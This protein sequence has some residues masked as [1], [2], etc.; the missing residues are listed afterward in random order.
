MGDRRRWRWARVWKEKPSRASPEGIRAPRPARGPRC[1]RRFCSHLVADP[2]SARALGSQDKASRGPQLGA[3][4]LRAP[5]CGATRWHRQGRGWEL[6]RARPSARGLHGQ[7]SPLSLC[8]AGLSPLSRR[9]RREKLMFNIY[10]SF[11]PGH[12]ISVWVN[13]SL[14]QTLLSF[15]SLDHAG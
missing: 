9:A 7:G 12:N 2:S 13:P 10:P 5:R 6:P 4:V 8:S 11:F 1:S 3:G 14:S 15:Q